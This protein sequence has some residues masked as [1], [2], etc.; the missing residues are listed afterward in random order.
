MVKAGSGVDRAVRGTLH[1]GRAIRLVWDASPGLTVLNAFLMFIQGML[2]LAALY[3]MKRTVDAVSAGVAAHE[4]AAAFHEALFWIILAA[5][6]A[7]LIALCRS[8]SELASEAHAQKVTDS[9]SDILHAQSVAVDLEYYEDSR[10]Y[11]T[12]HLAQ[13]Q[14]PYRPARMVNGLLQ[15]GQNAIALTGIAALLFSF[16]WRVALVICLAAFPGA[17]VRLIYSRKLYTFEAGQA[18]A[19]RRAWY[20]HWVL[21]DPGH[22]KEIR[23]FDLGELFRGRFSEIRKSLREGRISLAAR[24]AALDLATQGVATAA[25]FATFAFIC[26]R[27]INGPVTIGALVMYYLA[28]QSGLSFLQAVLR[29]LAGIYEDNLFLTGLYQFL[30]L[31]PRI[32][33]PGKASPVPAKISK[34]IIFEDV[35][36]RY[37]GK[38]DYVLSGIDLAIRPG[39]VIALVG[40]NGSGKTT[41]IKLLCRLYDPNSGRI[42]IDG[43]DMRQMDPVGLRRHISVIFQDHVRYDLSAR[44]NIWVGDTGIEPENP[45]IGEAAMLS[46]ADRVIRGL[47]LGYDTALGP[48]FNDGRELSIGEWQKVALARTFVRE[49][50]LVI[51]DEPTS[52]LDPLAEAELFSR[53]RMTMKGRSVIIISHRFSTVKMADYIYVLEHG[54]ISEHGT[55]DELLKRDGHYAGLYR[56]QSQLMDFQ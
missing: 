21:T 56:T 5:A 52:S 10:Y 51:L 1:L 8:V 39:Q 46:G 35:S 2:P 16:D 11:D 44:E 26:Y 22:A 29:G 3:L 12:L 13:Q 28:F 55:H 54:R 34:G 33:L 27:T 42:T 19:E 30:D 25:I 23:V 47:P 32:S 4:K 14:A 17:L 37:P 38:S 40:E 24:R 20:Y 49:A 45:K 50:Q 36:F 9:M 53:F 7:L 15:I 31:K 43:G 18:E 41:L 48:R 6:A